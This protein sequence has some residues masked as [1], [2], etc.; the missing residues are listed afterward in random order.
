LKGP[1]LPPNLE[2]GSEIGITIFPTALS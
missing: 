1:A 2:D